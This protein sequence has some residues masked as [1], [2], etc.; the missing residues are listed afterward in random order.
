[1]R[2]H[3]LRHG[4]TTPEPYY[5]VALGMPN[6]PLDET[7]FRQADLLGQRLQTYD[8]AALYSSDLRRAVETTRILQR[9]K[10]TCP[11]LT[12]RRGAICNAG[13]SH[14]SQ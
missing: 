3:L 4:Q 13:H 7:G 11:T 10:L 9:H 14:K 2:I 12:A 6:P 8:L 1:M 5:D